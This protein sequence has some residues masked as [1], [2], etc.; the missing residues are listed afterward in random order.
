MWIMNGEKLAVHDRAGFAENPAFQNLF[1]GVLTGDF[2]QIRIKKLRYYFNK[3]KAVPVVD[4]A[5]K[6]NLPDE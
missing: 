1:F 2:P 5:A 4:L 6:L 3:R